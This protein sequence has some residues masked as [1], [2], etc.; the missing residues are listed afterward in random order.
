MLD[1]V[2]L[3]VAALAA[4]FSMLAALDRGELMWPVM[5]G[6][7]WLATSLFSYRIESVHV[8]LTSTDNVVEHTAVYSGGWPLAFMFAGLAVLMWVLAINRAL[9][10]MRGGGRGA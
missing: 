6:V 2:F 1:A 10:Y 8:L 7:A 9:E 5:A 4:W 3:L